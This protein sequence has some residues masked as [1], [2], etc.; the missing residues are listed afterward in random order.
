MDFKQI[1]IHRGYLIHWS[2][3]LLKNNREG[4]ESYL[5]LVFDEKYFN[6]IENNFNYLLPYVV[7]M[8]LI[9]K[10]KNYIIKLKETLYRR[11]NN[12]FVNLFNSIYSNFDLE[13]YNYN[14][15]ICVESMKND[16]FLF[17]YIDTF[18]HKSKEIAIDNY[19]ILNNKI[20]IK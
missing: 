8:T 6:L 12:H 19:V 18:K 13:K 1:I 4:I 15:N 3:F 17:N 16:Y 5:N 11:N 14:L 9:S 20:D 2:L 10:N 7:V